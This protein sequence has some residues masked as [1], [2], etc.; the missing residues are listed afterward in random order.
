MH[1]WKDTPVALCHSN[2]HTRLDPRG[3]GG[4]GKGKAGLRSEGTRER[5]S[6]VE[7]E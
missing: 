7:S 6:E 4:E 3:E 1:R 2:R 5:E